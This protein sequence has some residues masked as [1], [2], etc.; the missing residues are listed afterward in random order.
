MPYDPLEEEEKKERDTL[1]DN[2]TE[3]L[4]TAGVAGTGMWGL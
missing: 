2:F 4:P 1:C 3:A